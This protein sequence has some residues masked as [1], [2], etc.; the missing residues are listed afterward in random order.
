MGI[1]SGFKGLNKPWERNNKPG[2]DKQT[3][4]GDLFDWCSHLLTGGVR[5]TNGV[6]LYKFKLAVRVVRVSGQERL[7]ATCTAVPL[8]VGRIA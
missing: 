8:L 7:V 6:H 2:F 5:R 3:N 1:N 4:S